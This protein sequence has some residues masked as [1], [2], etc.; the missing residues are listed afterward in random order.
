VQ[1]PILIVEWIAE[2]GLKKG[3]KFFSACVKK[4]G[5]P[6]VFLLIAIAAAGAILIGLAIEAA[7][8][9]DHE[10]TVAGFFHLGALGSAVA[11]LHHALEHSAKAAAHACLPIIKW[12]PVALSAYFAIMHLKHIFHDKKMGKNVNH[13]KAVELEEDAMKK[14]E[15]ELNS[16]DNDEIKELLQEKSDLHQKVIKFHKEQR[17]RKIKLTE[18]E[19]EMK[20]AKN[21][22]K[23]HAKKGGVKSEISDIRKLK[24][25]KSELK[26]EIK[27]EKKTLEDFGEV[28]EKTDKETKE[29]LEKSIESKENEIK[30]LEK[31]LEA[32]KKKIE[33]MDDPNGD[34]K[35]ALQNMEKMKHVE[36]ELHHEEHALIHDFK[37][38]FSD[39]A[40][41]HLRIK[42][43]TE[44][45]KKLKSEKKESDSLHNYTSFLNESAELA[46]D[47]YINDLEESYYRDHSTLRNAR[48]NQQI[49]EWITR[50]LGIEIDEE[51]QDY[52]KIGAKN[53][54]LA[55]FEDDEEG[56][57][58]NEGTYELLP[59]TKALFNEI[60]KKYSGFR[61]GTLSRWERWNYNQDLPVE[62]ETAAKE[63]GAPFDKIQVFRD[64]DNPDAYD[65]FVSELPSLRTLSKEG[66]YTDRRG[67]KVRFTVTVN[68]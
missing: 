33:E 58:V 62:V 68:C 23:D 39:E 35:G 34:A 66:E 61:V 7:V 41:P 31:A 6:G 18:M 57:S 36:H 49:D 50:E 63:L 3:L 13:S 10:S 17:D 40:G 53:K 27:D 14:D 56:D 12:I 24:E 26:S 16:T 42:A 30:E 45:I 25:K 32:A 59:K 19:K 2:Y 5:G 20:E 28:K 60:E 22:M 64:E 51:L 55:E 47:S 9:G 67:K 44:E 11:W 1:G 8:A 21:L 54:Y 37:K 29:G 38:F 4:L 46:F 43:I 65:M 15:E 48:A 52:A